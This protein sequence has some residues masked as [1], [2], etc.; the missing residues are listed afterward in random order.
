[1]LNRMVHNI[2]APRTS[3]Y[4]LYGPRVY[5][6]KTYQLRI[7]QCVISWPKT[8]QYIVYQYI[9]SELRIYQYIVYMSRY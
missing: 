2:L 3:Q 4:I 7:C 5:W 1:M 9:I 6:Y 8:C